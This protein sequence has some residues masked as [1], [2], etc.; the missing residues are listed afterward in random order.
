MSLTSTRTAAA[1]R[2]VISGASSGIGASL[3][4]YYARQ[5]A[6]LALVARRA[7]VLE[8][9]ASSLSTPC[10]VYPLD[11]RDRAALLRAGQDFIRRF[12]CPDIVIANAGINAGTSTEYFDDLAVIEEVVQTN[13][14][15]IV[16]TFH[17]FIACMRERGRGA[18]VG[19]ASVA[20]Y[21]GLPGVGAYSA[22]KAAAIS[23]MESL[24][25]ELRGTGIRVVT[26]CPGYIATPMTD[27]NPYPMPFLM[28]S[29]RAAEK[30][31]ALIRR[32][33][34]YAVIP[35]QMA[36]VARALRI[37]PN[38]LYDRLFARA[39]RKPRRNA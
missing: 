8:Q 7:G 6:E 34:T 4:R 25:T 24:R 20:G 12:G 27:D 14:L 23:Y 30:I 19:I 35:W 29:D 13:V 36:L 3:A 33:R 39:P 15:G 2:V 5:G 37:M 32:G 11:I 1:L 22:S 28:T 17:P 18:L 38:W 21:R 16:Q 26:I 9:L 31:G 10:A